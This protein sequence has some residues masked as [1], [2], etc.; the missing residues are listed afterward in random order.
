MSIKRQKNEGK[1]TSG[2]IKISL[3]N[4]TIKLDQDFTKYAAWGPLPA[5]AGGRCSW[6]FPPSCETTGQ[7][8]L[9]SSSQRW[10]FRLTLRGGLDR[11]QV[12]CVKR[13]KMSSPSLASTLKAKHRASVRAEKITFHSSERAAPVA[14][15]T[16][17]LLSCE[18]GKASSWWWCNC[19]F[20]VSH[21]EPLGLHS[22]EIWLALLG[23]SSIKHDCGLIRGRLRGL[24]ACREEQWCSSYFWSPQEWAFYINCGRISKWFQINYVFPS[25]GKSLAAAMMLFFYC[26]IMK[27]RESINICLTWKC[28]RTLSDS[29]KNTL[30]MGTVCYEPKTNVTSVAKMCATFLGYRA[31]CTAEQ[32]NTQTQCHIF[33]ALARHQGSLTDQTLDK[34]WQKNTDALSSLFLQP[35]HTRLRFLH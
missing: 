16:R 30:R 13:N 5:V 15:K 10:N 21:S 20:S 4:N 27:L 19:S 7:V 28:C 32:Q 24:P 3:T 31:H 9:S 14:A 11:K 1:I 26:L 33:T 18:V 6:L 22:A 34:S 2:A 25:M 12:E 8:R 23:K 35:N 29:H 17:R